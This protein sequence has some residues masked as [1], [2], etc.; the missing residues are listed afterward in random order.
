MSRMLKLGPDALCRILRRWGS[1]TPSS[2]PHTESSSRKGVV[3]AYE[4]KSALFFIPLDVLT[5]H[6]GQSLLGV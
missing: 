2:I 3:S 6:F 5:A 4:T 1:Q